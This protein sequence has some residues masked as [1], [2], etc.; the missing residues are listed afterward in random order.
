M[1]NVKQEGQHDS[2]I[3]ERDAKQNQKDEGRNNEEE[4]GKENCKA[5][6]KKGIMIRQVKLFV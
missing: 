2:M 6:R 3:E 1:D 4:D 5:I